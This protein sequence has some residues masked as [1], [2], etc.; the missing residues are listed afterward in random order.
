MS[1]VT[2][3]GSGTAVAVSVG[4]VYNGG[5]VPELRCL[6]R[7]VFTEVNGVSNAKLFDGF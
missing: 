2:S 6:A 7:F 1:T 4:A 3:G 5:N